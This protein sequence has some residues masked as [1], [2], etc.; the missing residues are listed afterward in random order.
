MTTHNVPH[1]SL[2]PSQRHVDNADERLPNAATLGFTQKMAAASARRPA[3]LS[4]SGVFLSWLLWY[5][6]GR[7]SRA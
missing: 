7:R 2:Q 3:A 5:W 4:P 1:A 6:S